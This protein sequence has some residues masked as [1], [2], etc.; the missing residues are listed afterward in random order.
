MKPS[1]KMRRQ[2]VVVVVKCS[3]TGLPFDTFQPIVENTKV[4]INFFPLCRV[5]NYEHKTVVVV[6]VQ[7]R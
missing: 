3:L 5:V 1:D 6:S 2:R 4:E 7:F